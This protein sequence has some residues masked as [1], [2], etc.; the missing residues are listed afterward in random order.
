LTTSN[1]HKQQTGAK[2]SCKAQPH[3]GFVE[4][5]AQGFSHRSMLGGGGGHGLVLLVSQ[6]VPR[7]THLHEFAL[8]CAQFGF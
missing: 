5:F 7:A 2:S 8:R 3:A 6:Y 1:F 4:L